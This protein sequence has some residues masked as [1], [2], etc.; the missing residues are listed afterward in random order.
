MLGSELEEFLFLLKKTVCESFGYGRT[1]ES[2]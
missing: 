1:D 2:L